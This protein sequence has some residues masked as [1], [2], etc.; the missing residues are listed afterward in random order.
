MTRTGRI[1]LAAFGLI[2]LAV[3]S[4]ALLPRLVWGALSGDW[5]SL[6]EW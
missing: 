1:T 6:L 4:L 2:V 5:S 3:V